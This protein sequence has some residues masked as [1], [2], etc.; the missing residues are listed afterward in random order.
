MVDDDRLVEKFLLLL[1][2]L[3]GDVP[4]DIEMVFMNSVVYVD[5][6]GRWLHF[7]GIESLGRLIL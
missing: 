3:W 4:V 1:E 7:N 5:L 2:R 6:H